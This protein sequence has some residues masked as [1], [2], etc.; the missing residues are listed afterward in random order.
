MQTTPCAS[1]NKPIGFVTLPSGKAMPVDPDLVQ[2]FGRGVGTQGRR[3]TLVTE[4]GFVRR[5]V[6]TSASDDGGFPIEGYVSHFATCPNA[7]AHR[8]A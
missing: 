3:I 7:A 8:R 1:C 2:T 4:Q 6:E 5:F